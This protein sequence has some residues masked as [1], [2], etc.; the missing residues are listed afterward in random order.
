M[1]NIRFVVM[2]PDGIPID[3]TKTY[4]T[5]KEAQDAFIKWRERY[6]VQG[7]Y[8]SMNYGRIPVDELFNY[9]EIVTYGLTLH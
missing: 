9:T 6:E 7:Y 8:S 5:H 1:D 2:S 4:S 3:P